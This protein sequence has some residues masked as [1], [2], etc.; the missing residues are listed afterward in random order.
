MFSS[1]QNQKKNEKKATNT[2]SKLIFLSS[3]SNTEAKIQ[4]PQRDVSEPGLRGDRRRDR[5]KLS[6]KERTKRLHFFDNFFVCSLVFFL[7]R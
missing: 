6:N 2:R 4:A 7:K 3:L 1:L 5:I